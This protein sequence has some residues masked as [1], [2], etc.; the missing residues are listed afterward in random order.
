MAIYTQNVTLDIS[1]QLPPPTIRLGQ[2]DKAGTQL[3]CAITNNGTAFTLT[4]YTV[5]FVMKL[6][7]GGSY[8]EASGSV[9]GSNATFTIDEATAAAVPGFTD[10]AYVE[11]YSGSTAI[12]STSRMNVVV[13]EG[14]RS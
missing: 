1:K 14:A 2:G 11:I 4:G 5:K 10:V 3:V 13:L 9:S 12:L 7:H 8:Y 6:P